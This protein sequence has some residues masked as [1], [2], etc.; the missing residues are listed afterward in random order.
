MTTPAEWRK[1]RDNF[2]RLIR[3]FDDTSDI[4]V[5]IRLDLT[6]EQAKVMAPGV[7]DFEELRLACA[8]FVGNW[9]A[10]EIVRL[11]NHLNWK[12]MGGR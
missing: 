7:E 8:T 6:R 1:D 10:P 5:A 9:L 2:M 12:A 3:D 4:P 11:E